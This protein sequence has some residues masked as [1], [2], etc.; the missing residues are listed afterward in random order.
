MRML[1]GKSS[2]SGW[3]KSGI[4][5]KHP[6]FATLIKTRIC[7]RARRQHIICSPPC[8]IQP[9][10]REPRLKTSNLYP[11]PQLHYVGNEETR[12]YILARSSLLIYNLL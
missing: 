1:D 5:D 10:E 6:G 12:I 4:R 8:P 11:D 7:I 9:D 2:D 3:K